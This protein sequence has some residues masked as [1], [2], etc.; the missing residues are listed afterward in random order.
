MSI[1]KLLTNNLKQ[2]NI[3]INKNIDNITLNEI[4]KLKALLKA[5]IVFL[6]LKISEIKNNTNEDKIKINKKIMIEYLEILKNVNNDIIILNPE[7]YYVIITYIKYLIQ[8][9]KTLSQNKT[10]LL[11][12]YYDYIEKEAMLNSQINIVLTAMEIGD[13]INKIFKCNTYKKIEDFEFI[14]KI[15]SILFNTMIEKILKKSPS[16][17]ISEDYNSDNNSV[18]NDNEVNNGLEFDDF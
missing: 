14:K 10:K 2:L 11:S 18:F 7:L 6:Q 9:N 4:N 16:N 8:D 13:D 5:E 17:S 12:Y 15:C 1:N 3:I